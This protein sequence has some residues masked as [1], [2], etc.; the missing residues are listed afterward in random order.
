VAAASVCLSCSLC[1]HT[2]ITAVIEELLL[3]DGKSSGAR[4]LHLSLRGLKAV[5]I[6]EALGDCQW[7]RPARNAGLPFKIPPYRS[8]LKGGFADAYPT[9]TTRNR[10]RWPS[11]AEGYRGREAG[12]ALKKG[13]IVNPSLF[14]K[15]RPDQC[16]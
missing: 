14:W 12:K 6:L 8:L 3:M 10:I 1:E 4:G 7:D 13:T 15:S 11:V 9:K 5:A 16:C 2:L